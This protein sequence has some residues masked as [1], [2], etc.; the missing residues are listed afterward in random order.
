M[1]PFFLTLPPQKSAVAISYGSRLFLMGSCFVENIGQKL[2][3]HKL[4]TTINSFGIVFHPAALEN[5][6]ERIIEQ[7]FFTI[8]DIFYHNEQWHCFEVH[9]ALSHSNKD[10]FTEQLNTILKSE[11]KQ[12]KETSH[13]VLTFGTAWG[14]VHKKTNRIVANCHKIPQQTFSKQLSSVTDLNHYF[15]RCFDLIHQLNPTAQIITTISPVRHIKDGIIDNNTS[16]ANLISAVHQSIK[17]NEKTHYYPAYELVMDCLR[18]Y[19]FYKADLVHPNELAIEYIWKHFMQTWLHEPHTLQTLTRVAEVQRGL[20]HKPFNPKSDAHL[21]F[22][23][24]LDKKMEQLKKE[25]S[26]ITF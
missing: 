4:Q 19:R 15:K 21:K 23:A 11:Y 25:Y 6:L 3:Y 2:A 14:Y 7:R 18:D 24:A 1:R 5:L 16:K 26:F 12:L 17:N 9:S 22:K 13:I 10:I 8:N 20:Q